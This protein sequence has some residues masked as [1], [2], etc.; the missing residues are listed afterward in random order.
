MKRKRDDYYYA[1][2]GFIGVLF[3]IYTTMLNFYVIPSMDLTELSS[4]QFALLSTS[5]F[6]FLIPLWV[7]VFIAIND[8]AHR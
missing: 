6:F 3:I 7:V 8:I 5:P 1:I 2:M 4:E